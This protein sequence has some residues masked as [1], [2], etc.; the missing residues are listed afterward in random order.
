MPNDGVPFYLQV[1]SVRLITSV[2]SQGVAQINVSDIWIEAGNENRGA[3]E[4][5]ANVPILQQGPVR[6]LINAGIKQSGQ[7]GIRVTYPFYLPD[8][9]TIDAQPGSTYTY[10]PTFRYA[11]GTRYPFKVE[12]FEFSNNY[13]SMQV[14][15]GPEV[16]S[17][18]GEFKCGMLEVTANDSTK[19]AG[20]NFS[21]DLPE[22]LEVWL[23]VSYKAEVPFWI[24]YYGRINT[25]TF[26]NDV[27]FVNPR[28]TW[29]KL[30]I[31][32]SESVGNLRADDYRLFFE[33]LKPANDADGGR[34]YLDNIK[35]VHF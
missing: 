19:L 12:D 15:S 29:N 1:D 5:P 28:S 2:D 17:I 10:T 6:F 3:Y 33:A 24:G 16:D 18:W 8:T 7:S 31:K 9:F 21:Y 20:Q 11:A 23:E 32:L 34:V 27:L 30:Y 13:D 4:L 14:Y 25:T 35:I 22:G 26:R